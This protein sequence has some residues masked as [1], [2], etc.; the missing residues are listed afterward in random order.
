MITAQQIKELRDKTG[1]SMFVCK[2]AL[3]ETG[4]DMEKALDVLQRE[5][6]KSAAKKADRTLESGVIESYIHSNKK[7]GALLE[8]RSESDFVS[9]NEEFRSLAKDLAMHI[10][11]GDISGNFSSGGLEELLNQPYIKN[12][13]IT[14]RD[15]INQAIQKFGEKIEISR[16]E[17]YSLSL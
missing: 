14:I 3:D 12:P 11:A 5:S 9:T 4:G 6:V 1:V 10:A 17:K 8:I 7:I 15:L 13:S 2:K 16:F